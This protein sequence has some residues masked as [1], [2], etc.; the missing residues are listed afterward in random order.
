M[1]PFRLL[2]LSESVSLN[3]GVVNTIEAGVGDSM[4][5]RACCVCFFVGGARG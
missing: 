1:A 5:V 3:G 2:S 4:A